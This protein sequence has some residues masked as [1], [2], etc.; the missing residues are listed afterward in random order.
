[1]D[2]Y[3]LRIYRKAEDDPRVLVGTAQK[4]GHEGKMAFSNLG[5]LWGI[6]NHVKKESERRRKTDPPN[7]NLTATG[8]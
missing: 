3:I 6:L 5:E 2:S 1:M 4:V 8:P 7:R